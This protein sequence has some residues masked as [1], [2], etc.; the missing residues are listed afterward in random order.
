MDDN[1]PEEYVFLIGRERRE[2]KPLI[3]SGKDSV[4]AF[5]A[6]DDALRYLRQLNDAPDDADVVRLSMSSLLEFAH[7][8]GLLL[9]E[10]VASGD[11]YPTTIIRPGSEDME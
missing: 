9:V 1:K 3:L 10:V 7:D 6:A 5:E 11:D 8:S 2:G 4:L